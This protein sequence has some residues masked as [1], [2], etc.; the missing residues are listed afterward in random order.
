MW[1]CSA[2]VSAEG[3]QTTTSDPSATIRRSSTSASV[4]SSTRPRRS[5][6]SGSRWPGHL[7][8]EGRLVA[9]RAQPARE[10]GQ[11][12]VAEEARRRAPRRSAPTAARLAPAR[13]RR[14]RL[15][16][17]LELD[18]PRPRRARGPAG[19]PPASRGRGPRSRAR[20]VPRP[21]S[22][23]GD[24]RQRAEPRA[25]PVLDPPVHAPSL[26]RLSSRETPSA[27]RRGI[28]PRRSP[29][30]PADLRLYFSVRRL[31]R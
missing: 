27:R 17:R 30:T 5:A 2:I 4:V 24:L 8:R 29:C 28:P 26:S 9:R 7:G 6:S 14:P 31:A 20:G 22:S 12:R 11:A 23:P 13:P 18:A 1:S 25:K 16:R 10:P 21:G 19:S 15:L 3:S